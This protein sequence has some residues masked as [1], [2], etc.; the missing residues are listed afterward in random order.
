MYCYK[1]KMVQHGLLLGNKFTYATLNHWK[2]SRRDNKAQIRIRPLIID[3]LTNLIWHKLKFKWTM[4]NKIVFDAALYCSKSANEYISA[5]ATIHTIL[6]RTWVT[7]KLHFPLLF[8]CVFET[9]TAVDGAYTLFIKRKKF[10]MKSLKK[11]FPIP[12]LKY[13]VPYYTRK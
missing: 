6:Y 9:V 3:G 4:K 11:Y 8:P 7:R 10:H 13:P 1:V 2:W 12:H 5:C